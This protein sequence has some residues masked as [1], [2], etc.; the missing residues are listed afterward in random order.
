MKACGI[1]GLDVAYHFSGSPLETESGQGPLILGH[2]LTGEIFE[3][4]S[5]EKLMVSLWLVTQ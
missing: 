3:L 4:G 1:C 2:E 5:I